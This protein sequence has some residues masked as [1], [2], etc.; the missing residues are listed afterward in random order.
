[1]HRHSRGR[2][3]INHPAAGTMD[4]AYDDFALPGDPNVTITTYTADPG[5]PSA[6]GLTLLVTWADTQKQPQTTSEEAHASSTTS[7]V[8][9]TRHRDHPAA[10]PSSPQRPPQT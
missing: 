4:L 8:E 7:T 6:D 3:T 5:T 9:P 10:R 2:K 1:M